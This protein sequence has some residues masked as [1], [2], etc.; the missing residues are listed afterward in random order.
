[1]KTKTAARYGRKDANPAGDP[2]AGKTNEPAPGAKA[3]EGALTKDEVSALVRDA[4]KAALDAGRKVTPEPEPK[5][6]ETKQAA[7]PGEKAVS[8]DELRAMIAEAT[9]AAFDSVR[10]P[11]KSVREAADANAGRSQIEIPYGYTKGNLLPHAKQ[12]L[13]CMLRRPVNEGID[14]ATL[15]KA[16]EIGERILDGRHMGKALTSVTTNASAELVPSDLSSELQR[17]LYL[18]SNL[19][20]LMAASEIN[21]PTATYT[22]PVSTT[23]PTFYLEATQNPAATA[24]NPAT[25][26]SVLTA[27]DFMAEVDLSYQ[28][29]EDSIVPVIPWLLDLLA[30]AAADTVEDAI[31]NGDSTA[32]HM[33]YDTEQIAKSSARAWKG[34][35]R[36]GI[37]VSGCN[38]DINS[39][40]FT[41]ANI[42]ATL[43]QMGKYGVMAS[44]CAMVVGVKT[45]NL[46]RA[47]DDYKTIEKAGN[48]ATLF[49]G[50]VVDVVYGMPLIISSRQREDVHTTGLNTTGQANASYTFSMFYK[51][52]F[53]LG[54]RREFMVE[55][56]RVITSKTTKIV[57][58]FRKAFAPVE[59]PSAT[60]PAVQIAYNFNS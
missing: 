7:D 21:M 54:R 3:D 57:A 55:T 32:T 36:L 30:K 27:R 20:A 56:E 15:R 24:T 16:E 49:N 31:L 13:N 41:I 48:R 53:F 5:A 25:V 37:G 18:N 40:G 22:L 14:D 4:V 50:N 2:P 23:R 34:L 39:G 8:R 52:N 9:K 60:V 11:A 29:E 47:L 43:A 12:F 51:P 59:V 38:K 33:D 28:L 1:M 42:G 58:S 44:E 19:A 26:S 6:P 10:V 17:R 46:L 45:Y 35:R